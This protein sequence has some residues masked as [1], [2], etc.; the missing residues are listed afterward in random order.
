MDKS[1]KWFLVRNSVE[2]AAV[3][4]FRS[5][6]SSPLQSSADVAGVALAFTLGKDGR[7][8]HV[9]ERDLN[10]QNWIVGELLQPG[11]YLKLLELGLEADTLDIIPGEVCTSSH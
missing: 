10:E 2:Q 3:R 5:L 11:G 4:S 1:I 6:L 9:I 8:I 7:R